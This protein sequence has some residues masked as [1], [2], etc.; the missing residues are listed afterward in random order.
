MNVAKGIKEIG[1]VLLGLLAMAAMLAIGVGFLVGAT[2]LSFWVL[3]WTP[4]AFEVTFAVSLLLLAPLSLIPAA[5]VFAAFGYLIASFAFGAI[6]WVWGVAFIYTAWG[7]FGLFVSVVFTGGTVV[8]AAMLAAL[9]HADWSDLGA[10][11]M[12]AVLTYGCRLH[13]MW[14]GK[15]ADERAARLAL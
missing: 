13:A 4:T 14:L 12:L 6:M 3:K 1:V 2:A 9:L 11:A 5:R 15:K 8:P 7:L 10:F